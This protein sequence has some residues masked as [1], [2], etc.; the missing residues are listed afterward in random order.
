MHGPPLVEEE[1]WP[2]EESMRPAL[3]AAGRS[4]ET[5]DSGKGVWGDGCTEDKGDN[6]GGR[7][8]GSRLRPRGSQV[9]DVDEGE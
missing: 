9:D 8:D 6:E 1:A 7:N 2:E 3:M 5:A 4:T